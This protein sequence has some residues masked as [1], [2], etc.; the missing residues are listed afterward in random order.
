MSEFGEL[1]PRGPSPQNDAQPVEAREVTPVRRP[2]DVR[3]RPALLA[4]ERLG[5]LVARRVPEDV[6]VVRPAYHVL[7]ARPPVGEERVEV[8]RGHVIGRH[9]RRRLVGHVEEL[10]HLREGVDEERV[11]LVELVALRLLERLVRGLLGRVLHERE[12]IAETRDRVLGHHEPV[13]RERANLR[14]DLLHERQQLLI[15]LRGH[16]RQPV[17]QDGLLER[18]AHRRHGEAPLELAVRGVILGQVG[19]VRPIPVVQDLRILH[20]RVR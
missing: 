7:V 9:D 12:S 14:E 5:P 3:V 8:L 6:G 4:V 1:L 2:D 13:L 19:L 11:V 18:G 10:V 16:T 17:D 20:L 15:L